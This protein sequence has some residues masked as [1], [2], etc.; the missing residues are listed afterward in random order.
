VPSTEPPE[1]RQR[2]ETEAGPHGVEDDIRGAGSPSE[3]QPELNSFDCHGQESGSEEESAGAGP[4]RPPKR[5]QDPQREQEEKVPDH[6]GHHDQRGWVIVP[7]LREQLLERYGVH[8]TL[9]GRLFPGGPGNGH[10]E[11]DE[12]PSGDGDI[13]D[14]CGPRTTRAVFQRSAPVS[15]KQHRRLKRRAACVEAPRKPFGH[16]RSLAFNALHSPATSLAPAQWTALLWVAAMPAQPSIHPSAIVE[17]GATVGLGTSI[18]HR[19]HVRAGSRIGADCTIGFAVYVDTEVVV[20][21][22]CKIQNHVSL[23]RGVILEDEVFVGPAGTFSN[24][25]YPRATGDWEIVP[26]YVRRGATIGAN[27]TIVCGVELG[28]WSM[29]AAGAVVTTDVPPHALVAGTPGRVLGWVCVCGR[30]VAG[31]EDRLPDSCPHC[32]RT[33]EE[34]MAS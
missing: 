30:R 23:F 10:Q 17:E 13:Q 7:E 9:L 22:R 34:M 29:I 31:A 21:D 1:E 27:A 18:W 6:L 20:G 28:A 16:T 19:S 24:D 2:D 8:D 14:P 33:A 3:L 11:D 32:G 5:Y 4:R 15:R 25:L 12:D 26:T